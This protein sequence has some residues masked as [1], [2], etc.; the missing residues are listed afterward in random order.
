MTPTSESN[1][2]EQS[3]PDELPPL[4]DNVPNIVQDSTGNANEP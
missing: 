2:P 3:I 4:P 1:E